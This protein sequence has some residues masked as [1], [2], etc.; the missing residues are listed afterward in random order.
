MPTTRVI[1]RDGT[2]HRGGQIFRDTGA[3]PSASL[4]TLA[5]GTPELRNR[6][7]EIEANWP[8]DRSTQFRAET[9]AV[10]TWPASLLAERAASMLVDQALAAF[11]RPE[12]AEKG[13]AVVPEVEADAT[14]KRARTL[15]D[16][17][18]A[19]EPIFLAA[20]GRRALRQ[21]ET[22][23]AVVVGR[24]ARAILHA[25]VDELADER[26][27]RRSDPTELRSRMG[28]LRERAHRLFQS[29]E[30]AQIVAKEGL[31]RCAEMRSK[32]QSVVLG[33]FNLDSGSADPAAPSCV[34]PVL[35]TALSAEGAI[36][37]AATTYSSSQDASLQGATGQTVVAASD[38][39]AEEEGRRFAAY[40]SKRWLPS[41]GQ[42]T[43]VYALFALALAAAGLLA[44]TWRIES[45]F[46]TVPLVVIAGAAAARAGSAEHA[47]RA[48]ERAYREHCDWQL[49]VLALGQAAE[50]VRSVRAVVESAMD[51]L[52][53][54]SDHV[55]GRI[56]AARLAAAGLAANAKSY[57]ESEIRALGKRPLDKGEEDRIVANAANAEMAGLLGR[58]SFA[59][60]AGELRLCLRATDGSLYPIDAAQAQLLVTE[61][62]GTVEASLR[63]RVDQLVATRPDSDDWMAD[64]VAMGT[65]PML[66]LRN[67]AA[68]GGRAPRYVIIGLPDAATS[69]LTRYVGELPGLTEG[70]V[71][72][73]RIPGLMF[74]YAV[75][76]LAGPEEWTVW[77]ECRAKAALLEAETP[78]YTARPSVDTLGDSA[79][80]MDFAAGIAANLI[81]YEPVR[82]V[83]EARRSYNVALQ[84]EDWV[85][86][87]EG[88]RGDLAF[89]ALAAQPELRLAV[90]RDLYV[91]MET[92]AQEGK[93]DEWAKSLLQA[94]RTIET[95]MP[96]GPIRTAMIE[97][98][99]ARIVD[100][101]SSTGG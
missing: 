22:S 23:A 63:S 75:W 14:R 1:L 46:G 27:A 53:D 67:G 78:I 16:S 12:T 100:L 84:R 57:R 48:W 35:A 32:T 66:S 49:D 4:V 11:Q 31:S 37:R 97:Y 92:A 50:I 26:E 34:P 55:G 65:T 18:T 41:A 24:E 77:S 40:A 9:V 95:R 19:G 70:H 60:V 80:V 43:A 79:T 101:R 89:Q 71:V 28:L 45:L 10:A 5:T 44:L 7:H 2:S 39:A 58:L 3:L 72:S 42:R 15:V 51:C 91:V 56:A 47:R 38:A 87:A 76:T 81:R 13:K 83:W 93:Q 33:A 94:K 64:L 86:L 8:A 90:R 59:Y 99:Y 20:H 82:S 29:S 6:V 68:A 85:R 17:L 61:T 69:P 52:S 25:P 30:A 21:G 73:T 98:L 96:E 54:S 36:G 74:V 88:G 62:A